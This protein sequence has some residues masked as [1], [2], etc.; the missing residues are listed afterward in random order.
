VAHD[1]PY[2][3]LLTPLPQGAK[4][5]TGLLSIHPKVIGREETSLARSQDIGLPVGGGLSRLPY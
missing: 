2:F 1:H 3:F 4:G 5:T